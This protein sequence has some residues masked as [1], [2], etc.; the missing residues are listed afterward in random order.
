MGCLEWAQHTMFNNKHA[1][2]LVILEKI[3]RKAC[4]WVIV[5]ARC[6]SEIMPGSGADL[7]SLHPGQ[8]PRF[9]NNARACVLWLYMVI[10]SKNGI[11]A[12]VPRLQEVFGSADE[13]KR[14]LHYTAPS[15]KCVP[16]E[17]GTMKI[18]HGSLGR[19]GGL[20]LHPAQWCVISPPLSSTDVYA[21]FYSCRQCWASMCR[22]L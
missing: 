22:G 20:E 3:K 5:G 9:A 15:R 13:R 4:L 10:L 16:L 7:A 17:C 19:S 1:P 6:S 12:C 18:S 2:Y 11:Q 8:P 21:R 14:P